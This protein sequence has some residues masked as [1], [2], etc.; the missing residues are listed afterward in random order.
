MLGDM[1]LAELVRRGSYR[2]QDLYPLVAALTEGQMALIAMG[3][4]ETV[5]TY[6][7]PSKPISEL[8]AL[9]DEMEQE[10]LMEDGV[11][12][13]YDVY[14]DV[15]RSIFRGTFAMTDAADRQQA[16]TGET[17]TW[18][19]AASRSTGAM[20][21]YIVAASLDVV[22]AGASAGLHIAYYV[23][24]NSAR[25]LGR[26]WAKVTAFQNTWGPVS[27]VGYGVAI[28]LAVIILGAYSI[29][30]WYNY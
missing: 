5:L 3:Q 25:A 9:L 29:S 20:I 30:T 13:P 23:M 19:D 10:F 12:T 26:G 22:V 7:S 16:L 27:L 8:N 1:S 4:L 17:W 2:I 15:D 18:S 28:G 6:N 11:F 21:G 14:L 24:R